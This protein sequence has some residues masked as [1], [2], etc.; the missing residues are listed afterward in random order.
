MNQ[1]DFDPHLTVAGLAGMLT[2]KQI[3][4]YKDGDKTN[5]PVRDIAKNGNYACQYG[6]GVSR[7]MITC[8]ID[9]RA[10]TKLYDAY[11]ELNWAVKKVA[12][13]QV[14]KTVG[15]QMWLKNPINGFY[16]SLREMK[17]VFSTLV[18]GTASYVFDMWVKYIL[19]KRP[20]LTG[21]FHDEIILCIKEGFEEECRELVTYAINKLNETIK[22]NREL[23][24]DIQFNKS[25]GKIH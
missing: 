23:G 6:A 15:D 13:V 21:Q 20:Q 9:R 2:E 19:E 10:A 17:D 22:L 16:Y 5:K 18:Q 3:Q 8:A 12:S 14:V 7:L 1:P 25:Y 11:W 4:E 24:I